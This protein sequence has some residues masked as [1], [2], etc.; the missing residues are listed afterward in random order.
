MIVQNFFSPSGN[1]QIY[2]YIYFSPQK[3]KYIYFFEKIYLNIFF[4]IPA[5][6]IWVPADLNNS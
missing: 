3:Y 4:Y 6:G 1:I 2:F 5:Q